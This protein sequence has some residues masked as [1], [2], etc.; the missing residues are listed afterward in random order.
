MCD[1]VL[2]IFV[3]CDQLLWSSV[4]IYVIIFAAHCMM[5]GPGEVKNSPSNMR[6]YFDTSDTLSIVN[7]K[8]LAFLTFFFWKY[9]QISSFY[10]FDSDLLIMWLISVFTHKFSVLS[11]KSGAD[12]SN[13]SLKSC[14]D[15]LF[16]LIEGCEIISNLFSYQIFC[17]EQYLTIACISEVKKSSS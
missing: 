7:N 1:L 16:T 14:N 17:G 12:V 5:V 2:L 6:H 10:R 3:M 9:Q 13:L 11:M 15:I 4:C 8:N